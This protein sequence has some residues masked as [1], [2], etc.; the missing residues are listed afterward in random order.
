MVGVGLVWRQDCRTARTERTLPCPLSLSLCLSNIFIWLLFFVCYIIRF[1][2]IS[3][4]LNVFRSH[5]LPPSLSFSVS[6]SWLFDFEISSKSAAYIWEMAPAPNSVYAISIR[7][8]RVSVPVTFSI[9]LCRTDKTLAVT[10]SHYHHSER[11][12]AELHRIPRLRPQPTGTAFVG[13][14][15]PL[16]FVCTHSCVHAGR[17][18]LTRQQEDGTG[19]T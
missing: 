9:R 17:T 3:I 14:S 2:S 15:V 16:S 11:E 12:P 13:L 10:T 1:P 7:G 8:G 5:S 19:S 18:V 4:P 6:I